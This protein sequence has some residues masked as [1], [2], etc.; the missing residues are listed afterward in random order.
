MPFLS[1]WPQT[2][3]ILRDVNNFRQIKKWFRMMRIMRFPP[4]HK[5][6]EAIAFQLHAKISSSEK[7]VKLCVVYVF[8]GK[9]QYKLAKYLNENVR[10]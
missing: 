5:A 8:H 4:V 7:F 6:L 10:H 3:P 9:P 2:E 1:G